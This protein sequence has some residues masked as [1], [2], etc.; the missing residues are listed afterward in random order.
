MANGMPPDL[1]SPTSPA[2]A[3]TAPPPPPI[4]TSAP[5]PLVLGVAAALATRFGVS[6]PLVRVAFAILATAGGFGLVAYLALA[7]T[8]RDRP[9]EGPAPSAGRDAGAALVV[10][11]L[12]WELSHWWP[13]FRPALVVPTGLVAA[14]VALG[15]RTNGHES[16]RGYGGS[17]ARPVATL[18]RVAGGVVLLVGGLAVFF[19]QQVDIG[20]LRDTGLALAV[21]LAGVVLVLGPTAV[22]FGRSF[23][24]ERDGRIRAQ[25]RAVVAAH[26]H[27]SVLQTLTLIQKRADDPAATAALARHQE[28]SLRRWLYGGGVVDANGGIGSGD[29]GWRAAAEAMVGHVEDRY[30]VAIELVMVGDGE[31]ADAEA[32]AVA[33]VVA[34]AR[35]ALVNAAKF[36]GDPHLSMF[37]ELADGRLD[38]FVRDRGTGFEL[39][40]IPADRRGIRDSIVGRLRSLGGSAAIRTRPGAGTEVALSLPV[41]AGRG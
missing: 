15:W 17:V 20:K 21:V 40:R 24:S 29:A 2:P 28:R 34:A 25:E 4:E 35:E 14:G 31:V 41:G 8:W 26:L 36:S 9:V 18:R 30:A 32:D 16:S 11:G 13:G 1:R 23:S 38:V 3:G 12:A 39:D 6:V 10:A 22:R 33:G 37:C 19:G 27:D 5:D 7:A